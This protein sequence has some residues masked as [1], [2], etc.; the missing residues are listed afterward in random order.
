MK[1]KKGTAIYNA[2]INLLIIRGAKDLGTFQYPEYEELDDHHI[3]PASWGRGKVG[4]EIHSILNKTPISAHTNRQLLSD[5]LPNEYLKEM[6]ERNDEKAV[7]EILASHFISPKAT[8]ILLRE[9]FSPDDFRDFLRERQS[10]IIEGI[11]DLLIESQISMEHPNRE[12][13]EDIEKI[14][15][16]L[17]QIVAEKVGPRPHELPDHILLRAKQRLEQMLRRD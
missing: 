12:L 17:R 16:R 13:D 2:I 15:L 14:E 8:K 3:V 1:N 5:R 10:T 6:F 7:E 9:D 4:S 11:K